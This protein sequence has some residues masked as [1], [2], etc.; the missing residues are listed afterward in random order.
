MRIIFTCGGTGGHINPAIAVAKLCCQ[1]IAD[2]EILFMGAEDGMENKLVPREGF[3]LETL[4]ISNFQRKLTPAGIWHNVTTLAHMAGSMR[5]AKRII[6]DF[7]PDVIFFAAG[8][9][10]FAYDIAFTISRDFAVATC[11]MIPP[12]VLPAS[13]SALTFTPSI[14]SAQPLPS[15]APT[16]PP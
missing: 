10:A 6:R 8:D 13:I 11:P 9:Y 15:T 3:R 12:T 16:I 5:K 1:R 4:K 7:A 2:C 14:V